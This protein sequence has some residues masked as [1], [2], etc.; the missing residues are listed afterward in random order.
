M[1]KSSVFLIS[2]LLVSGSALAARHPMPVGQRLENMRGNRKIDRKLI[3][4]LSS[5]HSIQHAGLPGKKKRTYVARSMP[6]QEIIIAAVGGYGVE[7]RYDRLMSQLQ[8]RKIKIVDAGIRRGHGTIVVRIQSASER[9]DLVD[10]LYR[11]QSLIQIARSSPP[12]AS[13]TRYAR[14]K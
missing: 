7:N 12:H 3:K 4:S 2:C 14:L 13:A 6:A 5:L 1:L 9:D 10:I 11:S 8:R